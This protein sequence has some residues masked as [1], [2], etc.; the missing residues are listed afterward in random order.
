MLINK[1]KAV[2]GKWA[3]NA[4]HFASNSHGGG[5]PLGHPGANFNHSPFLQRCTGAGSDQIRLQGK[6]Y[7]E[8]RLKC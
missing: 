7:F 6:V 3:V 8:D 4:K 1:V 2:K 5:K